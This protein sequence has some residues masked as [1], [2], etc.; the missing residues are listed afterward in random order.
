MVLDFCI[1][2]VI[3]IRKRSPKLMIIVIIILLL[4]G[5]AFIAYQ[6]TPGVQAKK[7]VNSFYSLEQDGNF[8]DSWEILH[9]QMN[10]RFDKA[11]YLE[12][13]PKMLL[14]SFDVDTF[15]Y[16]VGHSNK[17]KKWAFEKDGELFDVVYQFPVTLSYKSKF[18]NFVIQQNVYVTKEDEE[19]KILWDYK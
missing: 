18:G 2:G 3:T 16:E 14:L 19:W 5:T 15:T 7:V 1:K 8:D 10:D 11:T 6:F 13:R 9:A 17:M 4:G 12:K